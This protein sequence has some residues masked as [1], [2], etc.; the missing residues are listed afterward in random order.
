[1]TN[2]GTTTY[3]QNYTTLY[4]MLKDIKGADGTDQKKA[5]DGVPNMGTLPSNTKK[6]V[7]LITDGAPNRKENNTTLS[8]EAQLS[9][10]VAAAKSLKQDGYTVITVGLSVKDVGIAPQL[11]WRSASF[12]DSTVDIDSTDTTKPK[13]YYYAETG[14][15]LTWILREIV[16]TIMKE[17]SVKATVTDEIDDLFY[18]VSKEGEPFVS[19][20]WINLAGEKVPAS[21]ADAAGQVTYDAA[22]GTWTVTWTA[23]EMPWGGWHG[24]VFVKAKED[25]MG[26][27]NVSTNEQASIVPISYTVNKGQS[28]ENTANFSAADQE[29]K[30]IHPATPYVNVDELHLTQNNTEW[31]VYL[32]TEVDPAE[33]LTALWNNVK[34]NTVVKTDGMN[35]DY[36][37]NDDDK[38]YYTLTP[39]DTV[40]DPSPESGVE[41]IDLS[42]YISTDVLTSLLTDLKDNQEESTV[43]SAP[44]PYSPY[45]QGTVGNFTVSISKTVNEEAKDSAPEAHDT[46]KVGESVESYTL[47]INY[48]PLTE[49]ARKDLLVEGGKI[50]S[51]DTDYQ[52]HGGHSMEKE[53]LEAES[54]NTHV[55][56]VFAKGL[57]ITKTNEDFSKTLT[58]AKFVL[59]RTAR[60]TDDESDV[61]TLTGLDGSWYPAATLDCSSDGTASL[62]TVEKLKDGEQYYLV[63]TEVPAGYISISPIPVVITTTDYYI[64][65]AGSDDEEDKSTAKPSSGLYDLEQT[66]TLSLNADSGIKRTS[67]AT[68]TTDLT[69]SGITASSD[70]ETMYYRIANNPG[71]ELPATGGPGT[72]ALYLL[73]IML[74]GLAGAGLLMKRKRRRD[75]A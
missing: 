57:H 12:V 35:S 59:Y 49:A 9:R 68:N 53:A 33:Q 5:L 39:G 4:N 21:S 13:Y 56:N 70:N 36:T 48:V 64:Q 42:H 23:Q 7:V 73:G 11:L 8:T 25:F 60:S 65:P 38:M 51:D 71:V 16:R 74:T 45:G 46:E 26:G 18:P 19:G 28:N 75:A 32:G 72:T 37:I 67:D 69:H 30:T 52:H 24:S 61:T 29:N 40:D 44:I 58:R 27:N 14:D 17:A 1:M 2:T 54:I 66:A 10:V 41:T 62:S 15:N 34:V 43:V 50:T 31:T 22:S 47:T 63:E 3:E 55:I 20:E 6:Y